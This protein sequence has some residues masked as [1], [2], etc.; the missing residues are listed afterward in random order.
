M[1]ESHPFDD[2]RRH[3]PQPMDHS[4]TLMSDEAFEKL[5]RE[6]D[7]ALEAAS[8]PRTIRQKIRDVSRGLIYTIFF[9]GFGLV[10]GIPELRELIRHMIEQLFQGGR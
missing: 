10:M 8:R 1:K 3:P 2:L 4:T 5:L 6:H 7:D 9:V